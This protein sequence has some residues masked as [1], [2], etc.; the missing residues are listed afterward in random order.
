MTFQTN[1]QQALKEGA[2]NSSE[3]RIT[4]LEYSLLRFMAWIVQKVE[5]KRQ[6]GHK[7]IK[8]IFTTHKT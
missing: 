7:F 5:T 6:D 8:D 2:M 4:R 3:G 1:T